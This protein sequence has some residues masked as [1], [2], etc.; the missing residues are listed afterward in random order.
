MSRHKRPRRNYHHMVPRSR[1]GP[2]TTRNLLLINRARHIG[3]HKMFGNR[4]LNEVI[5]LLIRVRRAKGG[6]SWTTKNR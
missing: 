2:D 5:T 6:Q 1:S 3:W 4:T